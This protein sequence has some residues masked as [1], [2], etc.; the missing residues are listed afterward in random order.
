[1]TFNIQAAASALIDSRRARKLARV[2]PPGPRDADEAYLVQD[3]VAHQLG[4]VGGWKVGAKSPDATPNAAPLL[5]DLIKAGST[6]WSSSDLNICC[7]E[8]EIAFRIG[9]DIEP[10]SEPLSESEVYASVASIHAAIEI[11]DTRL[12][13]WD[14]ADPLWKLADNQSNGGFVY[15][16]AGSAWGGEGL[17]DAHVRLTVNDVVKADQRGGNPAGDP[18]WLLLWLV[19]HCV[20]KR[21]GIKAGSLVTT[22]SYAGMV[23]VEPRAAVKAEF[24]GIGSA[25]LRFT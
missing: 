24:I 16:P 20:R 12:V 7:I 9:C 5:T 2:L 4:P 22:G 21:G 18:R 23:F 19:D 17:A 14:T 11:V 1:M 15:D 25:S 3:A 8:P 6:G 10:R 13:D